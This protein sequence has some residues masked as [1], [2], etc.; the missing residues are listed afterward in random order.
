[1]A[2]NY[3]WVCPECWGEIFE[4]DM[5]RIEGNGIAVWCNTC[6]RDLEMSRVVKVLEKNVHRV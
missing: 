1:M 4:K 6:E 2:E 5:H 3:V